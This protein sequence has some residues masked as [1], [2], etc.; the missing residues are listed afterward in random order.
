[1]G[2]G[3]RLAQRAEFTVE[4]VTQHPDGRR[5]DAVAFGPGLRAAAWGSG[6]RC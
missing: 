5:H 4:L 3:L 1:V 2:A 6:W